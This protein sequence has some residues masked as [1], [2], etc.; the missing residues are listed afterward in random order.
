MLFELLK[1][2]YMYE[3]DIN[4]IE[5]I[6]NTFQKWCIAN[7]YFDFKYE[8]LDYRKKFCT[9]DIIIIHN[10]WKENEE[11]YTMSNGHDFINDLEYILDDYCRTTEDYDYCYDFWINE[12]NGIL[13]D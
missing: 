2:L 10:M 4:T 5:N 3:D 6:A 7:K 9:N 13:N 1:E 8:I 12:L 11:N